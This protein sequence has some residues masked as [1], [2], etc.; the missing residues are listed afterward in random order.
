MTYIP[1][2]SEKSMWNP[3][4]PTPT[5]IIGTPANLGRELFDEVLDETT[6]LPT[7]EKLIHHQASR[8]S[9]GD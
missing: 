7:G 9:L 2:S 3:H 6:G 1:P 5:G 4:N 8:E